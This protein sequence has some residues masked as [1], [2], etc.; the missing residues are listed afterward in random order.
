MDD[1]IG[2]LGKHVCVCTICVGLDLLHLSTGEMVCGSRNVY[3]YYN[4]VC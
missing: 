2:L 3:A 1:D 4:C